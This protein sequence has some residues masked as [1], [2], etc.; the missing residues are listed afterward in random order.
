ME[1]ETGNIEYGEKESMEEIQ[2][3]AFFYG[4]LCRLQEA[5]ILTIEEAREYAARVDRGEDVTIKLG[6]G[7]SREDM[8]ALLSQIGMAPTFKGEMQ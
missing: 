2:R 5:D 8:R 6:A 1:P 4:W 7:K 3:K